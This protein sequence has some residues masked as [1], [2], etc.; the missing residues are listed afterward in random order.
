MQY[1]H[2]TLSGHIGLG[3][4]AKN[5]YFGSKTIIIMF[6]NCLDPTRM[7]KVPHLYAIFSFQCFK[8]S[9]QIGSG[10]GLKIPGLG[11][12]LLLSCFEC[13]G[14]DLHQTWLLKIP[15]LYAIFSF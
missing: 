11:T 13:A 4:D 8:V 9:G 1:S 15:D 5:T 12:I 3:L 14:P 2:F 10:P 7:P 6:W